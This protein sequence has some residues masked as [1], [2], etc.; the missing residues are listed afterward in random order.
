MLPPLRIAA[1][2]IWA[3]LRTICPLSSSVPST[4]VSSILVI[5]LKAAS[6][7]TTSTA[8]PV[9]TASSPKSVLPVSSPI[10]L[11]ND[12]SS[13]TLTS[14][15]NLSLSFLIEL[16]SELKVFNIDSLS[17]SFMLLSLRAM[18]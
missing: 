1:A 2:N 9:P 15:N 17:F 13:L 4:P 16:N 8:W 10:F 14:D 5:S 6:S 3:L 11:A 18:S 7:S 12:I